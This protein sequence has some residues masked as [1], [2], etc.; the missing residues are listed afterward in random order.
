MFGD[1]L[2]AA[3]KMLA[4]AS[5]GDVQNAAEQHVSSLP[6]GEIVNHLLGM[7]PNLPDSA[8]SELA[9]TVL[10]ALGQNGTPE[11]AVADAGVPT[12]DA[13]DGDPQ[14]VSSLVQHAS[15]ND[16]SSLKD[17]AISFISNNPQLIQQYAPKLLQGILGR[18]G[19]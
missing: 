3:E 8:R 10:G 5:P 12:D 4:N 11:T 17:A 14:A 19:S 16:P 6:S 1:L 7:I 9:S 2:G 15:S 18:L 13:K